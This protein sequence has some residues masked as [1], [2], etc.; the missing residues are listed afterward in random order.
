MKTIKIYLIIPFLL[1][2]MGMG[3][4]EKDETLP[5]YQAKVKEAIE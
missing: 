1:L 4:C 2:L 5:P 3:G